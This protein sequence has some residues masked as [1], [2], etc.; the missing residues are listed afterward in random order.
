MRTHSPVPWLTALPML[1]YYAY[2][3]LRRRQPA[4]WRAA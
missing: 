2:M 4:L 3:A 1:G